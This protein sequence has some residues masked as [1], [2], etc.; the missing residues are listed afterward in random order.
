M[1]EDMLRNQDMAFSRT[2]DRGKTLSVDVRLEDGR[3][4]SQGDYGDIYEVNGFVGS[5][6]KKFIVKKFKGK[7]EKIT[8]YRATKAF[9]NYEVAK[10]AGLK[11]FTTYRI[12]ED[13]KSILMTNGN[14]ESA[15][16]IGN[17]KKSPK[18]KDL[19]GDKIGSL[20]D[21][22]FQTLVEGMYSQ[23]IL[24][25]GQNIKVPAD[26]YF[27]FVDTKTKS[28][29]DFVIGDL[30]FVSKLPGKPPDRTRGN[31]DHALSSID[32]FVQRN[33]WNPGKYYEKA[34]EMHQETVANLGLV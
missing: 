13:R 17:N 31:L 22:D 11:V 26:A 27:F 32:G 4:V 6:G 3:K 7:N 10:K 14:M 33:V 20:G 2:S 21:V 8:E 18:A 28:K 23:A 25:G 30:D 12:G 15:V 16:C 1:A 29:V 9:Q 5:H 19:L 24:A 34:K